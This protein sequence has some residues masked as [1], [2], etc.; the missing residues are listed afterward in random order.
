M[1]YCPITPTKCIVIIPKGRYHD[2]IAK[3][4][5]TINIDTFVD[6]VNTNL[7][8]FA[9]ECIYGSFNP[10]K[11]YDL[12]KTTPN[13]PHKDEVHNNIQSIRKTNKK[14]HIP[15]VICDPNNKTQH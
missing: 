2:A 8:Y 14:N 6:L 3:C 7:A 10:Q 13:Y 9:N 5:K 12:A 4:L 1:F 15:T 11:Y